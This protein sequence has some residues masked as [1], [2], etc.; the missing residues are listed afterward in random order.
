MSQREIK[1]TQAGLCSQVGILHKVAA[2]FSFDNENAPMFT[3]YKYHL[4]G[5]SIG[6]YY[7]LIFASNVFAPSV[8]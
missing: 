5:W 4:P 6:K 3:W 1:A 8:D 2:S 7:T